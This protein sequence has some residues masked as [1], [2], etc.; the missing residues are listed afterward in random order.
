MIVF[1]THAF[2][3][4]IVLAAGIYIAYLLKL[5]DFLSH[6]I[7]D[8]IAILAMCYIA[9]FFLCYTE[10]KGI[11]GK[12]FWTPTWFIFTLIIIVYGFLKIEYIYLKY[13]NLLLAVYLLYFYLKKFNM[14]FIEDFSKAN[15]ALNTLNTNEQ[16]FINNKKEF[17]RQLSHAFIFPSNIF[18]FLHPVYKKVFKNSVSQEFFINHYFMFTN[19]IADKATKNYSRKDIRKFHASL[20]QYFKTGKY[21]HR[22]GSLTNLARIIDYENG[23][24]LF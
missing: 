4:A 11:K 10:L 18:L 6:K 15:T 12:V 7:S 17:W 24:A 20:E 16:L 5:D 14:K 3:Q 2:Y 19:L 13:I 23:L 8:W 22:L 21:T 1:N 9:F